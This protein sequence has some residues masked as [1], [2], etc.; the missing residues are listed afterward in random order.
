MTW[1]LV[2]IAAYSI[3]AGVYV[4]DKFLLSKKIHSSITYAF[5]VGIWS[6][7][8]LVI[9]AFDPWTPDLRELMIDL[10][11]G[12][13]FLA[14][15]VF[16][17]KALHQSEATRV[18]PIVGALVPIFSF[19]FSYIFLGES[20]GER[21]LLAFFILINGGILISIKRTRIYLIPEVMNRFKN[22]FGDVLGGIHAAYRPTRRLLT[23]SV[24]SALFFAGYY[25]LIKYIYLN[26]PFIGSF[27]WSRVGSFLGAL[28]ILFIPDWRR[29]IVDHQRGAKTPKNMGFFLGVRVL[30][31]LAF[32]M[33]NWAISLGNVALVNSLQGAQYMFLIVI[34]FFLSTRYPRYLKEELGGGVML[35]KLI[36][37]TLVGTGL[38]M[39]IL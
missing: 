27:V 34:V 14:T 29:N 11:A 39:L 21:Q 8:N 1:L 6:I 18:V 22:I 2:A 4:A 31:A 15:L 10:L 36:G 33:L 19:I 37:A 35:Q 38:Y 24:T 16:W 12:M 17:Y 7:F 30:A 25:V 13:L 26:Q 20:L 9:L 32:I 3:N 23:N 5:Y 28:L